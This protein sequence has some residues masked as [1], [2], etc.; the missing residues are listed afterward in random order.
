MEKQ[1][2]KNLH[3]LVRIL[4]FVCQ[5]RKDEIDLVCNTHE[6]YEKYLRHFRM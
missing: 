2:H 3:K 1:F 4:K 5:D 6:K